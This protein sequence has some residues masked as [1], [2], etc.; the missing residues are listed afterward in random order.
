MKKLLLLIPLF[1]CADPAPAPTVVEI[2]KPVVVE[3]NKVVEVGDL[4]WPDCDVVNITS[5]TPC[6]NLRFVASKRNRHHIQ[7]A[8]GCEAAGNTLTQCACWIYGSCDWYDESQVHDLAS[9]AELEQRRENNRS[10]QPR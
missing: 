9:P 7:R 10:Y 8:E 3:T 5:E 2:E 6:K 4:W 1:A